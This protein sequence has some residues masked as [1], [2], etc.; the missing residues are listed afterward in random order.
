LCCASISLPARA[1]DHAPAAPGDNEPSYVRFDPI[2]VSVIEGNRVTRQVGTTLVLELAQGQAKADIEAKRKQLTDA[3]FQ[4]L[5]GFF[6]TRAGA[7]G[8]IDERYLKK[9]LLATASKV[10][11]PHAIKEVLIEQ[12]FERGS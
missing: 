9:R 2:F 7:R 8:K 11:G 10:V 6:Q 5:Y 3:F 12:L 4:E 1:A